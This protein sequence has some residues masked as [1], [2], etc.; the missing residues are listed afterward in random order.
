MNIRRV[1]MQGLLMGKWMPRSRCGEW[2][3]ITTRD[4]AKVDCKKCQKYL[5]MAQA[6]TTAM[7]QENTK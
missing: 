7:Q 4:K 2:Y 6:I 1:H 3:S 5:T